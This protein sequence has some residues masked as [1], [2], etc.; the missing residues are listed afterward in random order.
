MGRRHEA[1]AREIFYNSSANIRMEYSHW[2]Q[3]VGMLLSRVEVWWWKCMYQHDWRIHKFIMRRCFLPGLYYE[4][5][6]KRPGCLI[7][8]PLTQQTRILAGHWDAKWATGP[9]GPCSSRVLETTMRLPWYYTDTSNQNLKT[10]SAHLTMNSWKY[11]DFIMRHHPNIVRHRVFIM[12][13]T[14]GMHTYQILTAGT[15]GTYYGTPR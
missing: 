13:H 2:N 4:T 1:S 11:W 9:R 12:R 15:G 5:I 7:V 10:G 8:G 14:P 3:D 6:M